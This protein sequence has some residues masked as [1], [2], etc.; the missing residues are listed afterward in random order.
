MSPIRIS[1]SN[2]ASTEEFKPQTPPTPQGMF[3][4]IDTDSDSN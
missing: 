4:P 3:K 1:S 2:T